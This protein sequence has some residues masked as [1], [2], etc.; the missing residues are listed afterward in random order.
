MMFTVLLEDDT[1]S[2]SEKQRCYTG[3]GL[4]LFYKKKHQDGAVTYFKKAYQI[5]TE[6]WDRK[7]ARKRMKWITG[8]CHQDS[9]LGV[10]KKRV[11]EAFEILAFL[12]TEDKEEG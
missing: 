8:I 7:Q 3:F 1:S 2:D 10:L 11:C 5:Q 4:F 12:I 9:L 6:S